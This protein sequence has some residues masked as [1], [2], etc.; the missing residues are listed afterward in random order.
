MKEEDAK[1]FTS[2]LVLDPTHQR[3]V[4]MYLTGQYTIAKLAEL[5]D[6]HPN[7][8]LNWIKKPA[9][10][11]AIVEMQQVNNEVVVQQL[12]SLQMKAVSKLNAL[13]NSP[14]DGV[15][16]QAVKDVLDRNGHRAK[17]EIKIDKTVHTFEEKINN[18]IDRTIP[19][20]DYEVIE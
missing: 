16:L 1:E 14:I 19:D 7:T 8:I 2:L 6:V 18:L 17:T 20:T 5:F 9:V 10:A 3:F 11:S 15:A 12:Q 4:H 13:I